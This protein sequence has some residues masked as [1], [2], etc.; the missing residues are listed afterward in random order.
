MRAILMFHN[1]EEQSHKTVSTTTTFEEKGE[2]KRYRTEILPLTSHRLTARPN[3]LSK[4]ST[5]QY[6]TACSISARKLRVESTWR[7]LQTNQRRRLMKRS[8]ERRS[9]KMADSSIRINLLL[10][11]LTLLRKLQT[12]CAESSKEKR[13]ILAVGA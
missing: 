2:P 1:C 13:Y 12:Y 9:N 4:D 11:C 7:G 3:R 8:A 10:F 6:F 5:S